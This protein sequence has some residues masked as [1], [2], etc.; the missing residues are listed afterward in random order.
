MFKFD[1]RIR[2]AM[3]LGRILTM[4]LLSFVVGAGIGCARKPVGSPRLDTDLLESARKGNTTAVQHLLQQGAHI[5]AKDQ[6]GSTA[7]ALA[8]DYGHA[9]TVKLLMKEGAD[10]IVGGVNSS[11]ALIEAART[12]NANKVELLLQRGATLKER[13]EALFAV[14]ESEP[15]VVEAS[16]EVPQQIPSQQERDYYGTVKF[17]G[18][19]PAATASLLLEH[20]ADIES[21]REDGSAPLIEAAAFGGT[22]VVKQLLDR[23]ANVEAKDNRGN[24]ALMAAAC[25]CAVIDMPEA[26][27][28][29]KILLEKGAKV[30]AKDKAGRTAL[31]AGAFA[32]RTEN[33]QLLLDKGANIDSKDND[34]NT[35]LLVSAA[36]AHTVQSALSTRLTP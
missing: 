21:R 17:P 34:G 23:G 26:L 1:N 20:G 15:A 35:A 16:P 27:E 6:G 22:R 4:V 13:N 18:M 28:S 36:Q 12:A 14:G 10:P 19:D 30:N 33:M 3:T 5:E 2:G 7:L 8:A 29:M 11:D 25:E 32:G 9:D 31:M 24:T